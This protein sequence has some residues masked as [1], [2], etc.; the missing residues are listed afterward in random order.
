MRLNLILDRIE[1]GSAILV[2]DGAEVLVCSSEKLPEGSSEGDAFVGEVADGSVVSLEKR[3]NPR[4]G[5]NTNRLRALF[6]K[7]K[8]KR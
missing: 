6:N 1:E 4:A 3:E 2:G 8:N 7:N 5:Q